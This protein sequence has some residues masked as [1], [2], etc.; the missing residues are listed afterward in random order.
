M[1]SLKKSKAS[2]LLNSKKSNLSNLRKLC[3][4]AKCLVWLEAPLLDNIISLTAFT[5]A[6]A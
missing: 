4:A 5:A 6:L 2:A 1:N 3:G